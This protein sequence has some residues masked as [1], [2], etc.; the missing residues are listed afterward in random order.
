[1]GLKT[2]QTV[3]VSAP[4][5]LHTAPALGGVIR[6]CKLDVEIDGGRAWFFGGG[7]DLGAEVKVLH[8][9]AKKS[10]SGASLY[11]GP[12][13]PSTLD[14]RLG[15]SDCAA[16]TLQAALAALGGRLRP[17]PAARRA[18][19]WQPPKSPAQLRTAEDQDTTG[20][21]RVSTPLRGVWVRLRRHPA[22][23]AG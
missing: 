10:G 21:A 4:I 1:M 5:W 15:P 7:D 11:E 13:R 16:A 9:V 2:Y 6:A 19:A 22:R 12:G 14:L 17:P 23:C 3:P 20:C 8:A 18:G